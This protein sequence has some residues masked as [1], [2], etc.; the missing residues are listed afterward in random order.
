MKESGMTIGIG[1]L[2]IVAVIGAIVYFRGTP[3]PPRENDQLKASLTRTGCGARNI[4]V[5]EP[6]AGTKV[7]SP[8]IL[9]VTV[10]NRTATP[11]CSWTVFEAQ[12]G[13]AKIYDAT[14]KEIGIGLLQTSEDWMNAGPTSFAGMV[15]FANTGTTTT[16]DLHMVI[17]EDDPSGLREPDRVEVP[18]KQ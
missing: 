8:F 17:T 18:L 7:V 13:V 10:D 9:K 3:P 4:E 2:A 16:K 6:V 12:A 11:G 15:S 14:G 1:V 5:M